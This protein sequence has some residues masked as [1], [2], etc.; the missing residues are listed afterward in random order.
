MKNKMVRELIIIFLLLVVIVFAMGI[1]FYDSMA[2]DVEDIIDTQYSSSDE[3]NEV[4]EEIKAKGGENLEANT[5]DSLLKSYSI[6]AEDLS[7]YASENY[8]E[9]GKK[10]PFAETSETIDEHT[11]TTVQTG[12]A[13]QS[14]TSNPLE[15]T[16]VTNTAVKNMTNAVSNTTSVKEET[17][18]IKNSVNTNTILN[19]TNT[20]KNTTTNSVTTNTANK[21]SK[22]KNESSSTK[23]TFFEDKN[24]K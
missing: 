21:I 16:E 6:N 23:G 19:S 17:N 3:V 18:T 1:L 8:Y 10:D 15:N 11:T 4:L 22:D 5:T 20:V 2:E 7:R 12:N 9:S 14:Q 24:S 13:T